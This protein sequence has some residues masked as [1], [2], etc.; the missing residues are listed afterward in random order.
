MCL[1]R[2]KDAV[3]NPGSNEHIA[4]GQQ[5]R[6]VVRAR[7]GAGG[8]PPRS[9]SGWSIWAILRACDRPIHLQG[10]LFQSALTT[11]EWRNSERWRCCR[12]ASKFRSPDRKV[13]RSRTL[14]SRCRRIAGD[15]HPSVRQQRRRMKITC[16]DK[17]PGGCPSPALTSRVGRAARQPGKATG[18]LIATQESS[19]L[20]DD[21]RSGN[22]M[23]S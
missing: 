9:A 20:A 22:A 14:G 15:Q 21:R 13:P 17:A 6:R 18:T 8:C 1:N 2:E 3:P 11:S 16:R 23:F 5:R 12:S 10:T 7:S 19:S 4:T